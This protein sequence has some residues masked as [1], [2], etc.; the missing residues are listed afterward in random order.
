MVLSVEVVLEVTC[1]FY[2]PTKTTAL[3]AVV[4]VLS[5]QFLEPTPQFSILGGRGSCD[6]SARSCDT[7]LGALYLVLPVLKVSEEVGVAD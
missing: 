5:L 6:L 1:L 4:R 7:T 3:Q 2:L